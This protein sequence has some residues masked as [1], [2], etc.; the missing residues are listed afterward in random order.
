MAKPLLSTVLAK[1]NY[2]APNRKRT[3][4]R[5]GELAI[6]R[7]RSPHTQAKN[8]ASC[9]QR[10]RMEAKMIDDARHTKAPINDTSN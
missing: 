10:Y 3:V 5:N 9:H 4:A 6:T 8:S 1:A 2:R 7:Q